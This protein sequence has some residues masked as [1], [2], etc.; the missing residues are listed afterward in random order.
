MVHE[1]IP[2]PDQT[3]EEIQVKIVLKKFS[4]NSFIEKAFIESKTPELENN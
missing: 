2:I 4:Q 1:M 3:P